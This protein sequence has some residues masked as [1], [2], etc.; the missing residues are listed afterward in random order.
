M[1]QE[2]LIKCVDAHS[3]HWFETEE[4]PIDRVIA[5]AIASRGEETGE[6][7]V[8]VGALDRNAVRRVIYLTARHLK[9][10]CHI[11]NSY[12]EKIALAVLHEYMRP[13]C[14]H[15]GGKGEAFHKGRATT[16]C[17]ECEGTGK[18]RYSDS[19]R[20]ALIGGNNYNEK[21]YELAL[22]YIRDAM[23]NIRRKADARLDD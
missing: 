14:I 21:A 8:R 18:H 10:K 23:V 19:D 6:A 16:R 20:T 7:M 4:R 5:L 3:L 1:G 22:A 13:N 12:G 11:T 9:Y 17:P 15:C 2:R